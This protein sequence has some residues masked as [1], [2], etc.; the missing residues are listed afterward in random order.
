MNY[1]K[2]RKIL[3][4]NLKNFHFGGEFLVILGSMISMILWK[5]SI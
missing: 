2:K 4:E 3:N 5:E 1:R